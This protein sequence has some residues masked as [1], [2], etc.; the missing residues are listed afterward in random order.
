VGQ[1]R[2]YVEDYLVAE[3]GEMLTEVVVGD[4][5]V[6]KLEQLIAEVDRCIGIK[7]RDVQKEGPRLRA[8][9]QKSVKLLEGIWT[10]LR[11]ALEKAKTGPLEGIWTD[12]RDALQKAKSY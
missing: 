6:K 8:R 1:A 9:N 7:R 4:Q 2:A 11:R 12:L 10:D 5:L 3:L